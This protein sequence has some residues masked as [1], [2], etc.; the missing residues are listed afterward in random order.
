M[1]NVTKNNKADNVQTHIE[2]AYQIIDKHLPFNYV[3]L[4]LEK[5]PENTK[6]SKGMIRNVKNKSSKRIDILNAMVEVA[7]EN[8]DLEDKLKRL[9]T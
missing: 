5:L 1:T 2:K 7:L 6:I 3:E 8:K 4:V 9:T